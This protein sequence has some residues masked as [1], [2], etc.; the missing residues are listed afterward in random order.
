[1]GVTVDSNTTNLRIAEEVIGTPGI[2]PGTPIWQPYEPNSYPD[3]GGSTSKT[4]RTPI[5]ADRQRRKGSIT[6]IEAVAG[7]NSDFTSKGLFE[8]LQGFMF[9]TWRKKDELAVTAVTG[10][11]YTVA[12]GGA[13]FSA[14]QLIYA[15]GFGTTGNNGLRVAG[16]STGTSVLASGLTAEAS[17]PSGAK[18]T[19]VGREF[20]SGVLALTVSGGV[21]T[22]TD[23]ASGLATL[24]LIPGEWFWLGGDVAANQFATAANNGFY[25]VRTVAAGT[26]TCDRYPVGAATDTGSTKLIRMFIGHVIKNESDP[27]LQVKRTYQAE[28]MLNSTSYQYVKALGPNT[29]AIDVK[30]NDKITIDIGFVGLDEEFAASAKSGTRPSLP[31]NVVAFSSATDFSRLRLLNDTSSSDLAAYLTDLKLTIDNGISPVPAIGS[32]GG[33]DLSN[34]DFMVSGSVEAYFSTIAAAQA[35]QANADVALDF[36]LVATA[37]GLSSGYVFD[38]PLISMGDGRLKAEKDKPIKL[39]LT[40]DAAAHGT[41]NHT[42]MIGSFAYLP[43]AAAA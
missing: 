22:L 25:R 11:G 18:V 6:G 40:L 24:G 33:I 17:P 31:A 8:L 28:R 23:S 37:G 29:L 26:I 14:G 16:I 1:M 9:A 27:A 10:T 7:F 20:A 34:G 3:F 12:S 35:V 5:T 38:I 43:V 19:R 39:P 36:A 30:S 21:A 2:L 42:L 15:E 13:V 4:A 32:V 41:L